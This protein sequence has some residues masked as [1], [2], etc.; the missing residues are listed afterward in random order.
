[1]PPEPSAPVDLRS[2]TFTTPDAA[3]RRVMADAEVVLPQR[4]AGIGGGQAADDGALGVVGLERAAE[5]VERAQHVADVL[6]GDAERALPAGI[7][8][9]GGREPG[10]D[11]EARAILLQ[12]ADQVALRL[13]GRAHAFMADAEVVLP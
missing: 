10:R 8:A 7:A 5:I 11:R 4:I 12:G 6:I 3:M 9:I 2:D 13:Q 1:M